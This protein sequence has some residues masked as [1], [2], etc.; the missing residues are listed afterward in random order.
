MP[1]L[2]RTLCILLLAL[3][4][5][6]PVFA[7]EETQTPQPTEPDIVTAVKSMALLPGNLSPLSPKTAEK[8]WLWDLTT[9]PLYAMEADDTWVPVLAAQQPEDVTGSYAGTYGIPT[10]AR[11]HY[12]YR[13]A[14]NPDAC[15]DDG[16]P[17]T[18]DDYLFSVRQLLQGSETSGDWLFLANA[19]AILSQRQKPGTDIISL[20]EA[21]FS[22]LGEAWAAGFRDFYVDMDR[23]WGLDCGW[24]SIS[25][26]TRIQDYAMP[27]GLDEGFV[28]PAYLYNR[29]L[30][31]SA[32]HSDYQDVFLGIC[33]TPGDTFRPEDLGIIKT[34]NLELV[35]MLQSPMA[36]SALMEKL[37]FLFLLRQTVYGAD[38]GKTAEGYPSYG[39]YRITSAGV[40][41]ILLEPNPNWWGD[42]DPRGYHRILCQKIGT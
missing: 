41:E 6:Q 12:A 35:L 22:D 31:D 2:K 40:D 24:K 9:A 29:Y 18:A 14:L 20:G 4:L 26:R 42:P 33:R 7:E 15:W 23:F 34:G 19:S 21:G 38:D 36:V 16:T 1:Q 32:Q 37:Q 3:L 27:G 17:I 25:D 10:G 28:S 5:A 13:I 39:P 11:R 30:I 8:Q